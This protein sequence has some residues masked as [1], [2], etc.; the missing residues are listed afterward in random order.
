MDPLTAAL[1]A[2]EENSELLRG[3]QGEQGIEGP[4]GP[5][6]IRGPQGG[7]GGGSGSGS[8]LTV[9]D[10]GVSLDAAVTSIDFAGAGV[11]ATNVG[12]A[13]TVDITGSASTPDLTEVLTEGN[14]GGGLNIANVGGIFGPLALVTPPS[15]NFGGGVDATLTGG[16]DDDNSPGSFVGKAGN[17]AP[18]KV[19]IRTD[20]STGDMGQVLTAD[21]S[22][23][24]TWEDGGAGATNVYVQSSDPG[25]VGAG[26]LWIDTTTPGTTDLHVWKRNAADDGWED[27]LANYLS[28]ADISLVNVT[29]DAGVQTS[30]PSLSFFAGDTEVTITSEQAQVQSAALEIS[31]GGDTGTDGQ[32]LTAQGD[33]TAFWEDAAGGSAADD[34][35]LILHMRTF[36]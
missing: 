32:V 5:K 22:G 13:I 25:A 4:Q 3:P 15:L 20:D 16:D 31:I 6:G 27:L 34:E 24:A 11:T 21:G 29:E 23:N 10:E 9:K 2:V 36:A 28:G 12:H 8:A 19:Q 1:V 7:G 26:K 30:G 35:T 17:T 33:G 18:G 14:D